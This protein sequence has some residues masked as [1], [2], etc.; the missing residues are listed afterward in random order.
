MTVSIA[1]AL[2]AVPLAIWMVPRHTLTCEHTLWCYCFL[3]EF[4]TI[5]KCTWFGVKL[6]GLALR[7]T[8]ETD[9]RFI[10]VLK[11]KIPLHAYTN[12]IFQHT[13]GFSVAWET[14]WGVRAREALRIT[15]WAWPFTI[16]EHTID[17]IGDRRLKYEPIKKRIIAVS[18]LCANIS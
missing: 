2:N 5:A 18:I 4:P 1:V 3:P 6:T 13:I 14:R 11:R 12:P 17:T 10:L 15:L 8:L 16:I 9:S 7:C